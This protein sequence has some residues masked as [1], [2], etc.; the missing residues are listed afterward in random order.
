MTKFKL[1]LEQVAKSYAIAGESPAPIAKEF[2]EA[3][4]ILNSILKDFPQTIVLEQYLQKIIVVQITIIS[5]FI[6]IL[7]SEI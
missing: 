7:I 5:L 2:R 6:D 3:S 1:E 4:I